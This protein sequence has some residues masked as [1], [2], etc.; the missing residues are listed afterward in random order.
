VNGKAELVVQDA[1][2]Y[3]SLLERLDRLETVEAIRRGLK[4]VEEG[5]V[6]DAREA[7]EELRSSLRYRVRI[8]DA[9]LA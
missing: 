8:T 9:A 4:D 5:R 6:R 2:S 1:G 7:L 3:Q